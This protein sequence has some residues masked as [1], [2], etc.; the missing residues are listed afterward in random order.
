MALPNGGMKI[1]GFE[2][3]SP[4]DG[5]MKFVCFVDPFLF[6]DE[7][8]LRFIMPVPSV[9]NTGVRTVLESYGKCPY[10]FALPLEFLLTL[11]LGVPHHLAIEDT[12]PRKRFCTMYAWRCRRRQLSAM[13]T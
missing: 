8:M 9:W 2:K 3:A 1:S 7:V 5:V 11:L 10:P 12:T 13:Y 4:F 6:R